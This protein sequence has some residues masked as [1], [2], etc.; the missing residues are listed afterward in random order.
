M[1]VKTRQFC[2]R[3][4]I[5]DSMCLFNHVQRC[6]YETISYPLSKAAFSIG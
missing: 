2:I 3:Y 4:S 6:N 1:C 5:G